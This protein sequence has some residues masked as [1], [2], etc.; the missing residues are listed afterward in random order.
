MANRLIKIPAIFQGIFGIFRNIS[1]FYV[2][3]GA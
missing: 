1:S 3:D 2:D